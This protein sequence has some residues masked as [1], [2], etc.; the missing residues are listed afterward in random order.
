MRVCV[1]LFTI[2]TS[3][4]NGL[5]DLPPMGWNTW[6]TDDI[7]GLIDRCSEKLVKSIADALVAEG[8]DKL[9]YKYVNMDDCWSAQTRDSSGQLQPNAERFPSGMASL[10]DYVHSKGLK[11]G[12]YTC[13]GNTT[14]KNGLPGSGGHF[15]QDAQTL[16]SWKV[17]FVK[18]DFC[19]RNGDPYVLYHNF[20]AALNATGHPMLFSLCEWGT[21]DPTRGPVSAWGAEVGQMYRIQMDHIPFWHFPPKAA[22]E[23]FGQGTRDIIEYIA[24]LNPSK[25]VQKYGWMDP[26]FLETLFV[27][28]MT[29]VDSRT[30]FSF[31]CLWSAPLLVA[32]DI[33]NLTAQKREILTN[34]EVIAVDQDALALAGDRLSLDNSSHA[35][36]W[37]KPLSATAGRA[38][39]VILYNPTDGDGLEVAVQWQMLFSGG[40]GST[41]MVRDLWARKDLGN[42]TDGFRGSIDRHDVIMLKVSFPS[43]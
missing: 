26:D 1:L 31:W 35:Q 14:C 21:K 28:T 13:V 41:A 5:G 19:H 37:G 29:F 8:L 12:L 30:E 6:C 38:F 20:S 42:F 4:N 17:D 22:G 3:Y 9:G 39:C 18:S 11:L 7:C 15:V 10:V 43:T 2:V 25:F 24:T 16:A 33:R 27:P 23:G 36:V 40:A 32:T 34:P